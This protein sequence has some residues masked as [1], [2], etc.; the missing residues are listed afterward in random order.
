LSQF[1]TNKVI[2][3]ETYTR[4][5]ERNQERK[6]EEKINSKKKTKNIRGLSEKCQYNGTSSHLKCR[7]SSIEV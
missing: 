4:D 7:A 2:N 3:Q 5:V 6:K 1:E